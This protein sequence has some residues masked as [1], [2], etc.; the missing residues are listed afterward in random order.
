[1]SIQARIQDAAARNASLQHTLHETDSAVPDLESQQRYVADLERQVADAA[2][3]LEQLGR[4]RE[5]ERREHESYRDSVM[6]RFAYK[7][8]GRKDKFEARAAKE[9]REY[10]DVLQEEHQAGVAKRNLDEMLG[11]AVRVR[12]EL[13]VRAAAHRGAQEKLDGLY[14]SI[15]DGPSP[16][17]PEEDDRERELQVV[18]AAYREAQSRAEGEGQAVDLLSKAQGRLNAALQSMDEALQAS[19]MDVMGGGTI[20]DMMERNHLSRAESSTQQARNMVSMARQSSPFVRDLPSV[21]VAQGSMLGDVFF[22]NIFSDLAFHDKIHQSKLELQQ[23][24]RSL[25]ADLEAA[26]QRRGDMALEAKRK[27]AAM[28]EARQNLQKTREA[29]FE[30]IAG[31]PGPPCA[32]AARDVP[33]P[34]YTVDVAAGSNWWET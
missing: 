7:V 28:R 10:F 24:T 33:P 23:C 8:G 25:S 5:R 34:T 30:K 27:A 19:R 17:F 15:F 32:A 3:R 31:P 12:G 21:S 26:K 22:D 4:R 20:F 6:K 18:V 1:M 29:A 11:D 13:E 16:G 9:E 2:G 14:E